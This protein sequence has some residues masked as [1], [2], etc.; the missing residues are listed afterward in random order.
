M[1]VVNKRKQF[2][3]DLHSSFKVFKIGLHWW[4]VIL[5]VAKRTRKRLERTSAETII[6]I[7]DL[8]SVENQLSVL[9]LLVLKLVVMKYC[10]LY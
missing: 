6:S 1:I 7:S 8:D 2:L 10:D 3:Y 4:D 5:K 9:N